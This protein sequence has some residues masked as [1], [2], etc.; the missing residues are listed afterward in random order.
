MNRFKSPL[1]YPGGKQ[2]LAPFIS[3]IMRAN[4]L[5][6]GEYAE[7]YVGGAG[8]AIDLLLSRQASRV[9][10]NDVSVAVYAFWAT[11]LENS[12]RLCR[13]ISSA[14][15]TV[16]EWRRQQHI[17]ANPS[18]F[19]RE[20]LG[21]SLFYLNRC[22]RSGIPTGGLIGGLEQTGKWKMDARFTR[23]ELIRRVEAIASRKDSISVY[24]LDAEVFI[25]QAL[26]SLPK[27][28]FVYCDPPYYAKSKRLYLNNYAPEDHARIARVIMEQI[29][30]PWVVSY[31]AD[32][33]II[34]YYQGRHSFI[35]D[36][37]YNAG[38]RYKGKEIFVFSDNVVLP[39]QS[40]LPFVDVALQNF[41][42]LFT[43][44]SVSV[45]HT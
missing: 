28:T 31:D 27:H 19:S 24:N 29:K 36:L 16:P 37:R 44:A 9:H 13:R 12:E 22:N 11:L 3:E 35:Y 32:P 45:H 14:S 18:A 2:K 43:G 26:P 38:T 42:S 6:G 30:Q 23:S 34:G 20:E 33:A 17:L 5:I 1:R 25:A 4:R 8:V 39:S 10:L 7:P 41:G 15:L 40:S 21:F